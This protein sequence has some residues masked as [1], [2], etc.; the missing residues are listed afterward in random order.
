MSHDDV[1][2]LVGRRN[3]IEIIESEGGLKTIPLRVRVDGASY[4][5][6]TA[7]E[8][9]A[10]IEELRSPGGECRYVDITPK[11]RDLCGYNSTQLEPYV[12]PAAA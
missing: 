8:L 1:R 4:A 12:T 9:K 11:I 10:F 5:F 2:Q 6:L 7:S 3:P